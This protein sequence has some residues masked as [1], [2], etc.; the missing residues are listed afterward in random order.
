MKLDQTFFALDEIG[1]S[2]L[3]PWMKLDQTFF[4]LDEI[5]S[6]FLCLG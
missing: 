2:F 6:N 3:L 1:S 5:G 4:A